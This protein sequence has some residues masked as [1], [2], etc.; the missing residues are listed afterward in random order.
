[1]DQVS[2]VASDIYAWIRKDFHEWPLRFVLE[3]TAWITSIAC[4]TIMAFTL[5]HP[6][7][8]LL[9]PM[10]IAQCSIFAWAAWTRQSLGMLGN[11]ILLISIDIAALI[12][13]ITL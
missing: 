13:L 12:R 7:F 5:P 6:P 11:Y 1:M 8:L 9:Y 3:V 10:F 4:S 2:N